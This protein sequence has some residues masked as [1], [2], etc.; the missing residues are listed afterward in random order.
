[1]SILS[2]EEILTLHKAAEAAGLAPL[3]T[4]LLAG[5][6]P[7]IVS[8]IAEGST[9]AAGLLHDLTHLN[10]LDGGAALVV[11]LAN[12]VRLSG[13]RTQISTFEE[14]LDR[15][16]ARSPGVPPARAEAQDANRPVRATEPALCAP[17][18]GPTRIYVTSELWDV[19]L[20][21]Q[22]DLAAPAGLVLDRIIEA[23]RLPRSVQH[24]DRVGFRLNYSLSVRDRAL[25]RSEP[26]GAQGIDAG[27]V[28]SL[29]T[30]I[31]PFA[32]ATPVEGEMGTVS[33][34]RS[35]DSPRNEADRARIRDVFRRAGLLGA[36]RGQ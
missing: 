28:L 2:H 18:H 6:D 31:M 22:A 8:S 11:W 16:Q 24:D 4:T 27:D 3:R 36:E 33:F 21:L 34:R 1:M 23:C 32:G 12:A 29:V 5:L 17:H 19:T 15:L 35:G 25:G 20:P 13:G 7:Q 14:A 10:A 9:A 30:K 26:L